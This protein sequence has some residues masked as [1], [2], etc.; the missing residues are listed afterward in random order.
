[1]LQRID[2]NQCTRSF[3]YLKKRDFLCH[4][5]SVTE[6]MKPTHKN[7]RKNPERILN[8]LSNSRM[9]VRGS[10]HCL[11]SNIQMPPALKKVTS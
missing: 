7:R 1:M 9:T 5:V 6:G 11:E 10:E 4:R 2:A 8:P 3:V